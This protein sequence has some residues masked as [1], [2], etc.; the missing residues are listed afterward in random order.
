MLPALTSIISFCRLA[1][2]S[3]TAKRQREGDRSPAAAPRPPRT[4]GREERCQAKGEAPGEK[5]LRERGVGNADLAPGRAS[6]WERQPRR[7][8]GFGGGGGRDGEIAKRG[9]R[10]H[11]CLRPSQRLRHVGAPHRWGSVL[12]FPERAAALHNTSASA[13]GPSPLSNIGVGEVWW[14]LGPKAFFQFSFW[15]QFST[16]LIYSNQPQRNNIDRGLD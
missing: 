13:L 7:G 16:K 5:N 2:A 10:P 1:A 8:E 9:C 11:P 6:A 12:A 14:L 3:T 15:K 4:H